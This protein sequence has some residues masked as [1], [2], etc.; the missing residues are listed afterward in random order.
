MLKVPCDDKHGGHIACDAQAP[1]V[2]DLVHNQNRTLSRPLFG[3]GRRNLANI[4]HTLKD[5]F[6]LAD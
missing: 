3:E 1:D 2:V 4:D 6:L 5:N